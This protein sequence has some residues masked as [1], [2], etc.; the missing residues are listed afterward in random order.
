MTID[1]EFSVGD[2]VVYPAHGVGQITGEESQIVGG[3]EVTVHVVSFLKD[4]MVL[5]VPTRRAI[6]VGLRHLSNKEQVE[7]ALK[8]LKSRARIGRGMWSRRAQEYE[9]KINSGN[10]VYI[11]EVVRDLHKNVD[12]P[13]R[14]YSE[15]MI[16]ES[17]LD[18]LASE[19]AAVRKIDAGEAAELLVDALRKK[20]SEKEAA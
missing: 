17:A 5:R 9:Q 13:E 19:F 8:T 16:Y 6:K 1:I 3:M 18:R 11:A 4:K 7:K 20:E 2:Y 12:D 15:R 14:S 10:I